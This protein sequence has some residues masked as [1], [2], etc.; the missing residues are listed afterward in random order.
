MMAKPL[1]VLWDSLTECDPTLRL[2]ARELPVLRQKL[3]H[4]TSF[5]IAKTFAKICEGEI[6]LFDGPSVPVS[7]S[8]K[9]PEQ[10][11]WI[12]LRGLRTSF[13]RKVRAR[14][15]VGRRRNRRYMKLPELVER[16]ESEK[17][18]LSVTDLH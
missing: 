7:E 14:T 8:P 4:R 17:S 12:L 10:L 6:A 3:L 9:D 16:W 2:R 11:R 13:P 5:Q 1:M 15:Q 18:V